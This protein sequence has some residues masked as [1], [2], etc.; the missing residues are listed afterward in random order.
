MTMGQGQRSSSIG[1]W[2]WAVSEVRSL[3]QGGIRVEDVYWQMGVGHTSS[4]ACFEDHDI[5]V[6]IPHAWPAPARTRRQHPLASLHPHLRRRGHRRL[7]RRSG[8]V[9]RRARRGPRLRGRVRRRPL[10]HGLRGRH[11]RVGGRRV[12]V[13]H[14]GWGLSADVRRGGGVS[15]SYAFTGPGSGG[16]CRGELRG[17]RWIISWFI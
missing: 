10:P 11:G 12:H 16:A 17:G 13:G 8:R 6:A 15:A 7:G 5:H 4:P 1:T 2:C 14:R 9:V 3:L